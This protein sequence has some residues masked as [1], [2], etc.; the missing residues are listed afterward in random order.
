MN[1]NI[2]KSV[3]DMVTNSNAHS[4]NQ[5]VCVINEKDERVTS[6]L[7][8]AFNS[9]ADEV[10][11]KAK[12]QYPGMTYVLMNETDWRKFIDEG[13]I[14]VDGQFVTPAPYVPTP[15]EVQTKAKRELDAEYQSQ[16][17]AMQEAMMTALLAGN[18]DALKGIREDCAALEEWYAD[19]LS[20]IG[21]E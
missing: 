18:D 17:K 5:Y 20:N 10:M 21:K 14:Y 12:E 9:N 15:A 7:L 1:N 3:A 16:R 6:L 13:K 11:Q 4:D 19:E 8:N 2:V